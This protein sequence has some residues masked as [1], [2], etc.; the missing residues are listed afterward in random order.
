MAKEKL[1]AVAGGM[2]RPSVNIGY[3]IDVLPSGLEPETKDTKRMVRE[4]GHRLLYNKAKLRNKYVIMINMFN[5]NI[6]L[7]NRCSM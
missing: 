3:D 7:I 4:A 6:L 2:F 1:R 5:Y